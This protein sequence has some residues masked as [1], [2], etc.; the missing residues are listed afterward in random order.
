MVR[1]RTVWSLLHSRSPKFFLEA[2]ASV[3]SRNLQKRARPPRRDRHGG[4][5]SRQFFPT[6]GARANCCCPC[7]PRP[8]TLAKDHALQRQRER[9][10]NA[11]ATSL[12]GERAT[13]A[14]SQSQPQAAIRKGPCWPPTNKTSCSST[15]VR[16]LSGS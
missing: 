6:H 13:A 12:R 8:G 9:A 7:R 1:E 14:T 10:C 15:F 2:R 4:I 16:K 5:R 3:Q 11:P